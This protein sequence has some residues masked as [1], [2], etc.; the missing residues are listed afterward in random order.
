MISQNMY[1]TLLIDSEQT[2][3]LGIYSSLD[4]AVGKCNSYKMLYEP[5]DVMLAVQEI[6]SKFDG[7]EWYP[8]ED[9]VMNPM[10]EWSYDYVEEL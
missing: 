4:D 5:T 10:T 3:V 6:P 1:Y 9:A 7:K 8:D 2:T